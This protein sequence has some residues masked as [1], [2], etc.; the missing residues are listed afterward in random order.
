MRTLF[1]F[2]EKI[3]MRKRIVFY[4]AYFVCFLCII[5]FYCKLAIDKKKKK[6]LEQYLPWF[7]IF[8]NSTSLLLVKKNL[9]LEFDA[10][11]TIGYSN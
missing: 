11:Y 9:L 10:N 1:A 2:G 3:I 8:N 6:V 7:L 5:Y 4:S